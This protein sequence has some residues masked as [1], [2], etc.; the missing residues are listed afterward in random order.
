MDGA[1]SAA[2]EGK[3][4][5][6]WRLPDH[7]PALSGKWLTLY[8][9]LWA[10]ML[11]LAI[12]GPVRGQYVYYGYN[13]HPAWTPYGLRVDIEPAAL[14]LANVSSVEAR[15][16]GARIGDRIVA[17]DG[18]E[19]PAS[20]AAATFARSHLIKAEG[21]ATT[22]TLAPARGRVHDVRLTFT[23]AH[24][25]ERYRGTGL[26]FEGE[27]WLNIA[28]GLVTCFAFVAAAIL[29]FVRRRRVTI[30]AMISLSFLMLS[31]AQ[32]G[33]DW[34]D[35][36][37][38]PA[39]TGVVGS[40]GWALLVVALLAFP[41]GQFSP[42]WTR[43]VAL[44]SSL[45]ILESA[46]DVPDNVSLLSLGALLMPALASLVVRYRRFGV[47]TERQQLR[48]VFFGFVGGGMLW[49]LTIVGLILS[50]MLTPLDQ[51]WDV[52]SS[53]IFQLANFGVLFVTSGLMVS[54]LRYRLYDADAVIGRSAAYGVLT[55]GF[56]GLFAGAEKLTEIVGER[57]FEHSIGIAAGAI[58]AAVAAVCIVPLH[59]R[60]HGWAERRF[61]KPL[62]RLRDGLP[63]CI[64]DLRESASV[65]QLVN[66]VMA[67]VAAG[68][69]STREAILLVDKGK[70]MAAGARGTSA[71]AVRDWQEGWTEPD[72]E[73]LLDC[74][75]FDPLFPMR[76]RLCVASGDEPETIG[77]LLLGPRPDG[78]TLG[79]D[80]RSVLVDVAGPVARGVHIAQLREHRE[81]AAEERL[82]GLERLVE[83]LIGGL[84]PNG[85]KAAPA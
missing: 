45:L 13:Q 39:I 5:R 58:G 75:R 30:P 81:A 69:H 17:I 64:A 20:P 4:R 24:I 65:R 74:D 1:Y 3:S 33:A 60:V 25:A 62:I 46:V 23:S 61:Q 18:W 54:V 35:L 78:S 63:E 67:R 14:R 51:R 40:T 7:L 41:S 44:L 9:I 49:M 57:Y 72:G 12:I 6:S 68:V 36:G 70:M 28:G 15:R 66:A 82:T 77:W 42:R 83:K 50:K 85:G 26:T 32:F 2:T 80:E 34:R 29:L 27:A 10:I 8:T 79:K 84:S 16:A 59:D 47:G 37:V 53:L 21:A 52:W 48:W 73:Q 31:A 11:P 38:N 43:V 19:V 56:V 55:V 22:F 71:E 76:V